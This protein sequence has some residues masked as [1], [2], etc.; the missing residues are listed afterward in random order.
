MQNRIDTIIKTLGMKPHPEGGYYVQMYQSSTILSSPIN[1]KTRHGLTHIYFL[2]TKGQISRW[3]KVLH[4]EIWNIY[5]GAPLRLLQFDGECV[6]EKHLVSSSGD[7]TVSDINYF[8]II[9][10]GYFQAAESMGEYTLVGC[11]VAPGFS[12]EDFS[13]IENKDVLAQINALGNDYFKFI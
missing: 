2:L 11:S 8:G 6:E 13:Y 12:F 4:D 1:G 10:G 3:H 7:V 9:P 5:E